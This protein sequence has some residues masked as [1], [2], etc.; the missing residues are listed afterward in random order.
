[1][2]KEKT[3]ELKPKA[4]KISKEHL[5]ELQTIVNGITKI[6]YEIGKIEGMKH[7]QLHELGMLQKEVVRMQDVLKKEYGNFD[8]NISDGTINW[9][10]DE[11]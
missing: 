1:M 9:K 2:A 11:K 8:V 10:S 7:N 3:V 6:Q 4:D 5:E